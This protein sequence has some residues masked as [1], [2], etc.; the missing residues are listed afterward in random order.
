MEL[1]PDVLAI[2]RV[3]RL[4]T[5]IDEAIQ[6]IKDLED[7]IRVAIER[8]KAGRVD[9]AALAATLE[10]AKAEEARLEGRVASY[11]QKR[12]RTQQLIDL[13]QA[14]DFLVAR[15][16]LDQYAEIVDETELEQLGQMEIRE[17]LE[18]RL[19]RQRQQLEIDEG[20]YKAARAKRDAARPVLEAE[21]KA[22]RPQR[23]AAWGELPEDL[24]GSYETLRRK[25]QPV[26]VTLVDGVCTHCHIEARPQT[27]IE[28]G[29]QKATHRCRGCTSYILDAVE[30]EPAEEEDLDD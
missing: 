5:R 25:H 24:H 12:D 21:V 27:I 10:E 22:L 16:Q 3:A 13:G 11:A 2:Q 18:G 9:K 29:Q 8:V 7:G 20:R 15:K 4:D 23:A 1:H 17:A 28:V 30:S 6:A 19:E 26:L 14:P